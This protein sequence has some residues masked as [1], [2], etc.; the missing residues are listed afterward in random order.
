MGDLSFNC[1]SE[2]YIRYDICRGL[3]E[4]INPDAEWN[5]LLK[6]KGLQASLLKKGLEASLFNVGRVT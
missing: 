1:R 3:G 6:K 4:A 2:V 5:A